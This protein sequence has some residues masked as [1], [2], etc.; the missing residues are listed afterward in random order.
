MLH[1]LILEGFCF[2]NCST[3]ISSYLSTNRSVVIPYV[4]LWSSGHAKEGRRN[5]SSSKGKTG[6][7]NANDSDL[8]ISCQYNLRLIIFRKKKFSSENVG[9]SGYDASHKYD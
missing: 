6:K 4:G 3:C 9:F 8:A 7:G 2:S 5:A 1:K